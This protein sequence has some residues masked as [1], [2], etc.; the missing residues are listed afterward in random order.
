MVAYFLSAVKKLSLVKKKPVQLGI[1]A[2]VIC[3]AVATFFIVKSVKK[4]RRAI[5]ADQSVYSDQ[6]FTDLQ[7]DSLEIAAFF[8]AFVA[9][10]SIQNEVQEFYQ[11]R[12][13][14]LAWFNEGG[15]TEAAP[16][17]YSQ[18]E[19]YKQEFQ[20]YS[21]DNKSLSNLINAATTES[22]QFISQEKDVHELELLLTTTFFNYAEKTYSGSVKDPF[23]LEWFIPRKK[24]NYQSLLNSLV[25]LNT[26][27]EVQEPVN[28]YYLLLKEKLIQYREIQKNGDF[29]L[30]T[31]DRK[32]LA[33]GD[34]DSCLLNV[35]KHL[36]LTTDLSENDNSILYT[37]TLANAVKRFQRRMGLVE[38]GKISRA[39]LVELNV[40]IEKRIKQMIV[41]MERLRW[42]PVEM[43]KEYLLVN[44]PEFR[45]HIF[46]NQKQVWQMNVV[47]GKS[48]H[49][50]SIFKG[51]ISSIVLNPYWGVPTSIVRNEILPKL[52]R[53]PSYLT[54]NNMEVLSG[55]TVIDAKGIDWNKYTGNIPYN[56]R[57]KP[58]RNNSLGKIKFLFPNSYSIYLHD[59]PS[60]SLFNESSRAFSH[61]CIRVAEPREL[62]LHLLRDKPDWTADRVDKVLATNQATSIKISPKIPVYIAYFT[63]WVDNTGALNFRKDI[64]HL[65][66]K[67]SEEIFQTTD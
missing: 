21:L 35:K 56:I 30:V 28:H 46:N 13:Y 39:T 60:K 1:L 8:T 47:V 67:L 65:D 19:I 62:A 54:R 64:Y 27:E 26:S 31:T 5:L 10:D 2:F 37:D 43:E 52:K 17:F 57:Q 55:N 38:D 7:I 48:V 23:D 33:V 58:G 22:N 49:K 45:L 14:Q 41:N 61:G 59:T 12:N 4:K 20:D 63:T 44:I 11:R 50:T 15:I 3:A 24:K 32:L 36:F 53:D 40:P 9:T 25:S 51:N 29:P 42:A 34:S 18:L 16:S 6:N 66:E